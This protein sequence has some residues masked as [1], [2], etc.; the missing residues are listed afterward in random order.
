M[1]DWKVFHMEFYSVAYLVF[2]MEPSEADWKDNQKVGL[3]VILKAAYLV[4][5]RVDWMVD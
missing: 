2:S 1:V 4:V 5:M 3:K